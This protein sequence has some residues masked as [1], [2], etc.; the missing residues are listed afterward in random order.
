ML[1]S[2]IMLDFFD[3]KEHTMPLLRLISCLL[4]LLLTGAALPAL[5]DSP[6][7]NKAQPITGGWSLTRP[8][9]RQVQEAAASAV[10]QQSATAAIP[11]RLLAIESA[12]QQ[13]VAG[14]NYRLG[15]RVSEKGRERSALAIVWSRLDGSQQLTSW[16]WK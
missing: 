10:A 3:N 2:A 16:T 13:I 8:D 11:L 9:E 12:E 14:T 1:A 4:A 7:A 6:G 5:A 15:L